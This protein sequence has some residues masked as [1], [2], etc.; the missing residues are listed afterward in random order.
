MAKILCVTAAL[1]SETSLSAHH[2]R[3]LVNKYH[4]QKIDTIGDAYLVASGIL[5]PDEDGFWALDR[6]HDGRKGAGRMVALAV[7]MMR[8][9]LEVRALKCKFCESENWEFGCNLL[10]NCQQYKWRWGSRRM[11]TAATDKHL[12]ALLTAVHDFYMEFAKFEITAV[13]LFRKLSLTNNPFLR[14]AL[15]RMDKLKQPEGAIL[16]GGAADGHLELKRFLPALQTG[17]MLEEPARMVAFV[18]II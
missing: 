4:V 3:W 8:A 18:R 14:T 1:L 10:S 12:H 7:D 15:N 11:G 6:E 5:A 13:V 16:N 17:S 9:A 2:G